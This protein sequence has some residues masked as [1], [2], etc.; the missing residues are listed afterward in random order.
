MIEIVFPYFCVVDCFNIIGLLIWYQEVFFVTCLFLNNIIWKIVFVFSSIAL[1]RHINAIYYI[2]FN[3]VINRL[4]FLFP[5]Y[6][7]CFLIKEYN[8]ILCRLLSISCSFF[9]DLFAA[10][11]DIQDYFKTLYKITLVNLI[12]LWLYYQP[13][14]LPYPIGMVRTLRN[15]L[16]FVWNVY[17]LKR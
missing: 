7:Q 17:K 8:L 15:F 5:Q 12:S 4:W 11:K 6:L 2:C 9:E 1:K 3:L 16:C 14:A 13:S 10:L